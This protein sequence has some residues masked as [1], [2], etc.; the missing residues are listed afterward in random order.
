MRM[1]KHTLWH[2]IRTVS[3]GLFVIGLIPLAFLFTGPV[4]PSAVVSYF[5]YLLVTFLG[6]VIG[7]IMTV[8]YRHYADTADSK[9]KRERIYG[10]IGISL[11]VLFFL[12]FIVSSIVH[13]FSR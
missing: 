8:K 5:V 9:R 7:Q 12:P 13:Q 3:T 2:S 4:V 10:I 6:I 11:I 1:N